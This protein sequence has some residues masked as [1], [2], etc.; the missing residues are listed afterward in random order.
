MATVHGMRKPRTTIDKGFERAFECA[1]WL[2]ERLSNG[3]KLL[4]RS[5]GGAAGATLAGGPRPELGRNAGR[6][7]AVIQRRATVSA[8]V[9][10]IMLPTERATSSRNSPAPALSIVGASGKTKRKVNWK[11]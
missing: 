4:R 5:M 8:S 2:L 6:S 7:F 1:A 3:H 11:L 9:A 10:S